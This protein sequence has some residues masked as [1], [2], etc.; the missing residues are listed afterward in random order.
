MTKRYSK[1]TSERR[2]SAIKDKDIDFSDIPELGE[3]FFRNA[4]LVLPPKSGK[5][6]VTLRLDRDVLNWFK[7]QGK[8]HLTRMNAVLKAYVATQR[9]PGR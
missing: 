9:G 1:P 5:A 3:A 4:R 2:L 6:P 7:A 8:G